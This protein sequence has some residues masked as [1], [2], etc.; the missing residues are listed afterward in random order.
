MNAELAELL[1]RLPGKATPQWP[2]GERFTEDFVTWVAF[3]GPH[4]GE[5]ATSGH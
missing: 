5:P 2:Q 3:R 1:A 4:G